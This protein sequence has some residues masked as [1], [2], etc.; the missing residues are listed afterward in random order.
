MSPTAQFL[1]RDLFEWLFVEK[2]GERNVQ[3]ISGLKNTFINMRFLLH[4][5]P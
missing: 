3:S 5:F 2:L 4:A 1:H